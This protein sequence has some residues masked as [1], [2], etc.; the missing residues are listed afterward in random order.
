MNM[1]NLA[2]LVV[3]KRP[4]AS[5]IQSQANQLVCLDISDPSR[6]LAFIGAQSS[7]VNQIR[8]R[9][10][11]DESLIGLRGRMLQVTGGQAIV[12]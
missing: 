5:D 7:L 6:V 2:H 9:Q 11:E 4:F 10:F 1:G 8:G 12:D 3:E